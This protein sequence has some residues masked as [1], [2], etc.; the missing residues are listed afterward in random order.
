MQRMEKEHCGPFL[1]EDKGYSELCKLPS[2]QTYN[3]YDET[4]GRATEQHLHRQS[5]LPEN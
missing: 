2:Y 4:F 3:S 1:Q 5:N